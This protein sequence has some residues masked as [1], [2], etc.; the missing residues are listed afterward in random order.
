M[1]KWYE[2]DEVWLEQSAQT[3]EATLGDV[4]SDKSANAKAKAIVVD[5]SP[6]EEQSTPVD[7]TSN[8]A[9][10]ASVVNGEEIV[11][12]KHIGGNPYVYVKSTF[13]CV[14][15]RQKYIK[16]GELRYSKYNGISLK[17]DEFKSFTLRWWKAFTPR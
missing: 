3:S 6:M 16:D 17:Q 2:K 13:E 1:Q 11:Y 12:E 9:V 8:S 4:S 7:G 14:Q 10:L 15:I 5:T